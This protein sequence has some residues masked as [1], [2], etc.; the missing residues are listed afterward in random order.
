V[1]RTGDV[2][3]AI[4]DD[5]A[6]SADDAVT[7]V[8]RIFAERLQG[9]GIAAVFGEG[10]VCAKLGGA[11]LARGVDAGRLV[12]AA[13]QASGG[14]GGGQ[15]GFGRG[16]LGDPSRRAEAMAAFQSALEELAR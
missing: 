8:D 15:P 3:L 16:G 12:R 13:A 5:P 6:L 2:A 9:D 10:T 11:A 7:L 4:A 1:T 14:R